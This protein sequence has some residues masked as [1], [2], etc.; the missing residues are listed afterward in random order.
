MTS[1]LPVLLQLHVAGTAV[2]AGT[3]QDPVPGGAALTELKLEQPVLMGRAFLMGGRLRFYGTA[4]LEGLTMD[5]GVLTPGGF[6]EGFVDRRHPHTYVHELI[7]TAV[8]GT[9]RAALG[10]SFSVGKGFVAFGSD[11]PMNRPALRFPVNHHFAQILERAVLIAGVRAGPA[12]LEGTLFNG[13]EPEAP[14]QWPRLGRFGDSWATRLSLTPARGVE[15]AGSYARVASPEHRPGAG[16]HQT[17]WH[18]GLRVLRPAGDGRLYGLAEWART[19]DA[20]G[21][22]AFHSVLAEIEW[23]RGR[24]RP[25]YRFERTTRPEEERLLDPFRSLRPH[26]DDHIL[27][28]TRFTVHT[29]GYGV[30][31]PLPAAAVRAEPLVEVSLARATTVDGGLFSPARF[32]GDD[33]LWMVT[34]GVRVRMG[35]EHRMGRYGVLE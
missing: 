7:G 24:H 33:L 29:V 21:F 27:G 10:A 23:R 8:L 9:P 22:F 19:T 6:G 2:L 34:L 17:K 14:E 16:P 15:V 32:Y 18:A 1:L 5:D 31:V 35:G 3:H 13:D 20:D 11:D 4:N 28:T 26:L 12:V 30:G 25:Y